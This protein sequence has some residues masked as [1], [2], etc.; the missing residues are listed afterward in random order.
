LL[1]ISFDAV[2]DDEFERLAGY[3]AIGAF[4]K[5][6][7]VYR[8]VST[9]FVSN[10]YP[11]H[12]SV[13]TGLPPGQHGLRANTE[14]RP[15]RDPVWNSNEDGIQTR[16]LWQAAREEGIDT[17]AVFWP[18]T[19][20]SKTIRWNMPEVL[21]RP[22]KS[23]LL[24][25]LRAGSPLTQLQ[26]FLKHRKLFEGVKQ[27]QLDNF[28][29]ACMC[30]IL[31]RKK[32]GLALIHFTAYDTL[33]HMHGKGGRELDTAFEALDKNLA[34]LLEAAKDEGD[35]LIFS[36]HS[37]INV[38]TVV[39]INDL[40]CDMEPDECFFECCGG[41]AFFHSNGLSEWRIDEVK[42]R[43]EKS[44]GFRRFLMPEEMRQSG[45]QGHAAFGIAAQA[46]YCY[47]AYPK[48]IKATHG[49][50]LDMPDYK[51]FYMARGFGLKSGEHTGGSLLDIAPLVAKRLKLRWY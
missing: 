20:Y 3:P 32:P 37:Q 19:A 10:T 6:A 9:V 16:T 44:E 4:I 40:I 33:C 17:A 36:D 15:V 47:E 48:D 28:A 25:S 35:V 13:A 29:T 8:D 21:A 23:Q 39:T 45:Y 38:H 49:Y 2:G 46:G 24:T 41:S 43:V 30:D 7:A 50:A 26:L 27:P 51:V 22:G 18:V 5:S 14:A 12:T 42:R 31:R 34:A 1:I 11:I